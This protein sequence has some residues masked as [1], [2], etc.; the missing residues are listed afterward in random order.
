VEQW[1]P[2]KEGT[3]GSDKVA[4]GVLRPLS[5][6]ATDTLQTLAATGVWF[7]HASCHTYLPQ[8]ADPLVDFL[9]RRPDIDVQVLV[10]RE[11]FFSGFAAHWNHALLWVSKEQWPTVRDMFGSCLFRAGP[12]VTDDPLA[13][14]IECGWTEAC[15]PDRLLLGQSAVLP[16]SW[17]A[18]VQ[19]LT[20]RGSHR[21][22]RVGVIRD[23]GAATPVVLGA[24]HAD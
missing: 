21:E 16:E 5:Y 19:V 15:V 23:P 14:V 9:A 17:Q 18:V 10:I 20:L 12:Q 11:P 2:V 22:V 24:R 3:T 7:T 13:N 8:P 1:T 6:S 4:K